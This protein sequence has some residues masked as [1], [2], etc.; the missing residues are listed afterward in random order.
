M[1]EFAQITGFDWEDGNSKKSTEKHSVIQSEAE[2]IFFNQPLLLL[3][4]VVHSQ[5]E[6]RYHALGK[7]DDD[8]KLH[9]MFTL[10]ANS[11]LIRVISARDMNRKERSVYEQS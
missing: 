4:D 6:A 11:T 2:Q 9:V 1:V 7:T 5:K 3:D 8:R 10:R